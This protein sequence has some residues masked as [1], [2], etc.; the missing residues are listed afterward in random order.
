MN[1]SLS[2][3]IP[4]KNRPISLYRC[5]KSL[6]KKKN[7]FHEIIVSNDSEE[8]FK[9]IY[10]LISEKFNIKIIEGPRQGLY[11]NHN[12]LYK[13][14]TG[15]HVRIVDDDHIFPVDHFDICIKFINLY[16]EDVLSFGESYFPK[17]ENIFLPGEL[18]CRGFSSR[19]QNYEYCS[20]LASGASVFPRKI[21]EERIFEIDL[22]PFGMTWLEYGKRLKKKGFNIR[23]VK[24]TYVIHFYNDKNRSYNSTDLHLETTFFVMIVNNLI[25]EKKFN[26]YFFMFYEIIKQLISINFIKKIKLL[27]NAFKNFLEIKN[28]NEI[29]NFKD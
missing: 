22:Y 12:Y 20:A 18:N 5:L 7:L 3:V 10:L 11:A 23:V 17:V 24:D 6:L 9:N 21:F 13:A 29:W 1:I 15:S 14:A 19:P 26:N 27:K 2:I 28:K 4:S 8:K 16:P 25:Y